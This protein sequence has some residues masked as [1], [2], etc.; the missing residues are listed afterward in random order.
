MFF[1]MEKKAASDPALLELLLEL[2]L[3]SV[4]GFKSKHDDG[5]DTV[6]MLSSIRAWKPSE[7]SNVTPVGTQQ[8]MWDIEAED[9]IVPR[10]GSYIV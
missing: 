2:S 4:S 3:V 7:E 10:M 5:I 8:G 9:V 6:S 1:P